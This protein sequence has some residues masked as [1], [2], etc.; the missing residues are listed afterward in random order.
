MTT[1]VARWESRSGKHYVNLERFEDGGYGYSSPGAGGVL[2]AVT[3]DEAIAAIQ[4]LVNLDDYFQPAANKTPM[5][6]MEVSQ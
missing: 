2:S 1:I 3:L 5:R 6:R 4:R